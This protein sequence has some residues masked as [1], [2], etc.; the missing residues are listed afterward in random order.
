MEAVIL[1][2]KHATYLRL[3]K[4]S[5]ESALTQAELDYQ[6]ANVDLKIQQYLMAS[7]QEQ[8]VELLVCFIMGMDIGL[9]ILASVKIISH[10]VL[11]ESTHPDLD[12]DLQSDLFVP[13]QSLNNSHVHRKWFKRLFSRNSVSLPKLREDK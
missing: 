1:L 11:T 4:L 7:S 13:S 6:Q 3:S 2:L 8:S 12:P 9:F 10:Q 5:H